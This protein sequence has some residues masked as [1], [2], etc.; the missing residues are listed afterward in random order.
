[1]LS[2]RVSE[3][4]LDKAVR[5]SYRILKEGGIVAF[6]T[7]TFY[8]LGVKYD[9]NNALE[10]LY[11]LKR[12]PSEKAIPL[13]LGDKKQLD[14]IATTLNEITE[15]LILKFWPGPLTILVPAKKGLP[16]FL[17]AGT[18]KVAV[19]IPGKS[20]ALDLVQTLPFPITATSA[21]L[22]G[23]PPADRP[24]DILYYFGSNLDILI[25]DNKTKGGKPS[26]IV[27]ITDAG[28][29]VLREGIFSAKEI[30]DAI[31]AS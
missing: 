8:A 11:N 20:F 17:T 29:K 9:D 3:A 31:M 10:R 27:D 25:D 12:R 1:M 5:E 28:F 19:R 26:T 7:E 23:Y 6:P 13:I 14:L 15:K 21:N 16:E 18:G 2:I 4:S 22:S 30:F 24:D